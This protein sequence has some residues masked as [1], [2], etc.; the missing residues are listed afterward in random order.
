MRG[1]AFHSPDGALTTYS[2]RPYRAFRDVFDESESRLHHFQ[3]AAQILDSTLKD[4]VRLEYSELASQET[5]FSRCG[6][7]HDTPDRVISAAV[8]YRAYAA[9]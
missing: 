9:C 1:P 5:L 3:P 6:M 2:S 8:R 4:A 7:R